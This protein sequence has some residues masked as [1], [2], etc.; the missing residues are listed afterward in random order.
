VLRV[1]GRPAASEFSG[2]RVRPRTGVSATASPRGW[3]P[4]RPWS[5]L[6]GRT[7]REYGATRAL[8][9][10]TDRFTLRGGAHTRRGP[11]AW[12]TAIQA[13]VGWM[14]RKEGLAEQLGI[15]HRRDRP[16]R[17]YDQ[18]AVDGRPEL[19]GMAD[20][21]YQRLIDRCLRAHVM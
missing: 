14:T 11:S 16:P 1:G 10:Q 21:T 13:A 8:N 19:S 18:S 5:P 20:S 12:A 15:A 2:F 17:H 9:R 3:S 6:S 7:A 4:A